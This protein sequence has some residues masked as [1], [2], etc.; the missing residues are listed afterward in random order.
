MDEANAFISG[1]TFVAS[2]GIALF[3]LR[4]WRQSSDRLFAIFAL[5]F[6]V[7]AVNRLVLVIMGD[8]DENT[9][10]VYLVRLAAFVLILVAIFDRNRRDRPSP[11]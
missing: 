2:A 7:F 9:T 6:A 3:F 1:A 4:F 5:A 8:D 11:G 10:Y